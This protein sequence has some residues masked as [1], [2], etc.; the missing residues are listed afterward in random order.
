MGQIKVRVNELLKARELRENRRIMLADVA[1]DTGI[2]P[3]SLSELAMGN[4]SHVSLLN[5][6]KLCEYFKCTT[7]EV[8]YYDADPDAL[9]EDEIE[10]RDIVARWDQ[11]YGADEHPPGS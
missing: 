7:S 1:R 4:V 6:A 10:S 3:D 11:R 9:D 8:L 2:A 5:L